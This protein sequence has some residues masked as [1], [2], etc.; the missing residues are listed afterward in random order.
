MSLVMMLSLPTLPREL[1]QRI[2]DYVDLRGLA[3]SACVS[4]A[5]LRM[6]R[7]NS[8]LPTLSKIRLWPAASLRKL[9]VHLTWQSVESP[10]LQL[11]V[12]AQQQS[13]LAAPL[14]VLDGL[15][16]WMAH[17]NEHEA[18][19]RLLQHVKQLV[20]VGGDGNVEWATP[21][22]LAQR[23]WLSGVAILPTMR[24]L[25]TAAHHQTHVRISFSISNLPEDQFF[26]KLDFQRTQRHGASLAVMTRRRKP[27]EQLM[28][29][30]LTS[31]S[32]E[33]HVFVGP[34]VFFDPQTSMYSVQDGSGPENALIA[35]TTRLEQIGVS[36][37]RAFLNGICM[38][39]SFVFAPAAQH[40]QQQIHAL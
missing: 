31:S 15:A 23:E 40:L 32:V 27:Q 29:M 18:G 7:D 4:R 26:L 1:Q 11:Q 36:D 12:Q 8:I 39:V 9:G 38:L 35:T 6:V 2:Y 28:T 20:S 5:W 13:G 34:P 37:S 22:T 21:A 10:P 17:D 33:L 24:A 16:A 25:H 14:L 30:L 3:A 19:L